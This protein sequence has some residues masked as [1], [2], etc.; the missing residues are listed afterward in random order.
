M[1]EPNPDRAKIEKIAKKVQGFEKDFADKSKMNPQKLIYQLQKQLITEDADGNPVYNK[2]AKPADVAD[3]V[4]DEFRNHLYG[5]L[6]W[7]A[8]TLESDKARV[9]P[10]TG[11][12]VIDSIDHDFGV[13][14]EQVFGLVKNFAKNGYDFVLSGGAGQAMQDPESSP[15][16]QYVIKQ[17]NLEAAPVMSQLNRTNA[18]D[19]QARGFVKDALKDKAGD[20]NLL[21]GK[22]LE[23]KLFEAMLQYGRN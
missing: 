7:D 14:T 21:V 22:N 17:G 2:D 1:P 13:P 18:F 4:A 9:D 5:H 10:R 16:M 20:T 12:R 23:Q 15:I 6:G 11:N 19:D 3:G 8:G